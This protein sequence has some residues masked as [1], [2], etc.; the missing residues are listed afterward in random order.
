[1]SALTAQIVLIDFGPEQIRFSAVFMQDFPAAIHDP[2]G[3]L[4]PLGSAHDFSFSDCAAMGGA[5]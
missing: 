4:H 2:L 1:L 3:S 5:S